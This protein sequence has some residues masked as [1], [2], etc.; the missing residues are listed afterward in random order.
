[1]KKLSFYTFLLC[2]TLFSCKEQKASHQETKAIESTA[3]REGNV[4][5]HPISHGSLVLEYEDVVIYIDP[6]GGTEAFKKEKKPSI[7]MITDI[8]GDHFDIETLEAVRT[9]LTKIIAPTA[10]MEKLPEHIKNYVAVMSNFQNI[11][12]FDGNI[13]VNIKA[14]PMYNLRDEALQYHPIGRGNGYLITL[15]TDRIYISGDTEDIPEM[16]NLKNIDI[17]FVCMNLP[18]TMPV[19]RAADAVLAFKP[20]TVF[21]YHYRGKDGLSDVS[22]FKTLVNS[23]NK[24]IEVVQL[25]WYN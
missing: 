21:P 14:I 19:E 5:I 11:S 23:K 3:S 22:L 15:G 25:D 16:R 2:I 4:N 17:A 10:V 24:D 9:P 1:M 20:K 7:I 18:Y 8:H 12:L 13:T 6:V